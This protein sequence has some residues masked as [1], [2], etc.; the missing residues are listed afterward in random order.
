MATTDAASDICFFAACWSLWPRYG[1]R[2]FGNVNA[3]ARRLAQSS[4]ARPWETDILQ[5]AQRSDVKGA[6][7]HL[8]QSIARLDDEYEHGIVDDDTYQQRRQAYKE[9]LCELIEALQRSEASQK[10]IETRRRA[11]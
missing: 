9:Q 2:A 6:G 4:T 3:F 1:Y 7:R 10:V 5:H 8:L 11:V